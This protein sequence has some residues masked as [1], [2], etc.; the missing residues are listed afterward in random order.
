MAKKNANALELTTDELAKQLAAEYAQLVLQKKETEKKIEE[1]KLQLLAHASQNPEFDF[2]TLTIVENA[3]A[4]KIDFGNLT[5]KAQE[6]LVSR[7]MEE[8]PDFVLSSRKL[9]IERINLAAESN[10]AVRNA[11]TAHGIKIVSE[12]THT[13]RINK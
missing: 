7:L 4:P 5:K 1:L 9:D 8:L 11:L 12:A 3:A 2:G 10:P 6:A 13:I